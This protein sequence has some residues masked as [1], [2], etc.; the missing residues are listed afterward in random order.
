MNKNTQLILALS[1]A[2]F[3]A[4]CQSNPT[5]RFNS[6]PS[7]L[8]ASTNIQGNWRATEGPL[9]ATFSG[10]KFQSVNTENN[11]VVASGAFQVNSAQD[12]QLEWVGAL[13][14]RSSAKCQLIENDLMS[15]TPSNGSGFQ[16]RR[17]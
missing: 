2:L 16:L 8:P 13:S 7:A 3:V 9:M 11:Q 4:G 14:G 12:I 10:S 5:S 17:V 1:T 6:T 15:C